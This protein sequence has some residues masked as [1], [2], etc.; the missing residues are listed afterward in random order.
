MIFFITDLWYRIP[1]PVTNVLCAF[2]KAV[3]DGMGIISGVLI[4]VFLLGYTQPAKADMSIM[5]ISIDDLTFETSAGVGTYS[6]TTGRSA[7]YKLK[8]GLKGNPLYLWGSYDTPDIRMLGQSIAD[9]KV[10]GAGV[11]VTSH[12]SP[13]WSVFM[14]AGWGKIST[15]VTATIRDEVVYA[16]LVRHHASETR[17]IPAGDPEDDPNAQTAYTLGGGFMGRVGMSYQ[18]TTHL[19]VT[20]SYRYF[21]AEEYIR[22][23]DDEVVNDPTLGG[24]WEEKNKVDLSAFE[25]L[26]T[27]HF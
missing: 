20:T 4:M 5:D 17:E 21:M 24:W 14:D 13:Y 10:I 23:W 18:F 16:Q 12:I 27:Y 11:G 19:S 3:I 25:V 15:D 2:G 7:T 22:L 6:D 8:L 1:R 26:M 9:A